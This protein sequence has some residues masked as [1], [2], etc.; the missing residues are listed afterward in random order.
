VPT[1]ITTCSS[2][3]QGEPRGNCRFLASSRRP[4]RTVAAWQMR[5]HL[6]RPAGQRE[7]L[8]ADDRGDRVRVASGRA[9][10]RLPRDVLPGYFTAAAGTPAEAA[11]MNHR[12]ADRVG[13]TEELT[14]LA[15][16]RGRAR[17]VLAFGFC[18]RMRQVLQLHWRESTPTAR[19]WGPAAR[20]R[21]RPRLT[22]WSHSSRRTPPSAPPSSH[23]VCH[24]RRGELL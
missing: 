19:G 23:S 16:R 13:H 10:S 18:E 3:D 17:M 6:R 12:L 7:K 2:A 20:T 4:S 1:S 8:S 24:D 5:N 11:S 14:R 21:C 15:T 9:D 22:T